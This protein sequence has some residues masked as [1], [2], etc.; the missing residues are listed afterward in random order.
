MQTKQLFHLLLVGSLS[1]FLLT[2]CPGLSDYDI[3]LPGGYS[4]IRT[5]A[6]Q[7]QIAL[8]VREGSWDAPV[9]PTK[10]TEVAW[11]DHYIMAKQLDLKEDET[12]H[13]G[14]QIP[15]ETKVSFW[16]LEVAT[17]EVTGPLDE[18]SY[19]KKKAELGISTE[20]VLQEID[21]IY[22]N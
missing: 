21:D 11:D 6:H 4:V 8:E 14:Y 5:S 2:G 17:G 1:L 15:D 20:V 12:S 13:N 16:I 10:V 7:V 3:D 18:E 9:I 19:I 22:N